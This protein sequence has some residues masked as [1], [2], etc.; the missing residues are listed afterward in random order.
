M[1]KRGFL[2][3]VFALGLLSAKAALPYSGHVVYENTVNTEDAFKTLTIVNSNGDDNTWRYD[4]HEHSAICYGIS[5][6]S[7]DDWLVTP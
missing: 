2:S 1:M 3:V 7:N 4:S 6:H 5:S